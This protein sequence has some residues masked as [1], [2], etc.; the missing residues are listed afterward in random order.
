MHSL[1]WPAPLKGKSRP[2]AAAP[3]AVALLT[4]AILL[5]SPLSA[6][7]RATVAYED[8]YRA[9]IEPVMPE[10]STHLIHGRPEGPEIVLSVRNLK[11]VECK[12]AFLYLG[13]TDFTG[14]GI[15]DFERRIDLGPGEEK[16][17]RFRAGSLAGRPGFYDARVLL[18]D[19]GRELGFKE[20]TFGYDVTN[21]EVEL[22]K[23]PDFDTFWQ[24][25]LD[26]LKNI[27]LAPEISLES[28]LSTDKVQVYRVSFSSLH[29]V[30]VHGWYTVPRWKSAPHAALAFYPGYS[31]GRISPKTGFSL[32]GYSTLA[33]QVRGY[34]PDRDSYPEDNRSYMTLG[35]EAPETYVFREII[36]HSLRAVEFLAA[37]PEVDPARIGTVGGSQ[38]GGLALFTAG[39]DPRISSVCANVPFLADIPRAM[40]MTGAPCRDIVRYIEKHTESKEKVTRTLHFFDA[41]FLAGKIKAPVIVSMGLFDR[42]CPAPSIY[43]MFLRLGSGDKSIKVYP[44]LD[45]L[46]VYALFK[47]IETDWLIAHL[48]PH[49]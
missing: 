31:S 21:L 3:I 44:Y 45:H 23:P 20:F 37:R 14:R 42:T 28:S 2:A 13:L 33:I 9:E 29:G 38:G 25:T 39:L 34:E 17:V 43:R 6:W 4:S 32:R 24:A 5:W 26:S 7:D 46:E 22:N 49:F 8:G 19:Q 30:R 41:R 10:D 27:P 1:P 40:T 35:L 16:L 18:F 36:C 48:P 15:Q 12:D 47:E 11:A